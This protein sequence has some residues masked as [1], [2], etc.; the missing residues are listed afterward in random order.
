M[1]RQALRELAPFVDSVVRKRV[2]LLSVSATAAGLMEAAALLLTVRVAVA[3]GTEELDAV[4][5]PLVGS[6]VSPGWVLVVAAICGVAVVG[7]HV[8]NT[9]LTADISSR[10]LHGARSQAVA[11]YVQAGWPTQA[12][13]REGALQETVTTLSI[14]TSL[15]VESLTLGC[16]QAV[17]L[18]VFIGA[19]MAVD[20]VA[21]GVVVV[22]GVALVACLRP[23][24]R[25]TRRRSRVYVDANSAFAE[26]VSRL[27]STSM[28]LRVFGVQAAAQRELAAESDRVR[29]KQLRARSIVLL[30]GGL[31]KD[32]AVLL[33][34]A[35]IGG[36][37][38]ADTGRLAGMA[39]VVAL[40]VRALASAQ[41]V[42]HAY[43]AVN[44]GTSS[45]IALNE[46]LAVLAAGASRVGTAELRH[47]PRIEL[48]RVGY[49]YHDDGPALDEVSLA[50]ESGESLGVV[51]PSGGGKSTFVQVLL[52]LRP[53]SVGAVMIDGTDYRE[54]SDDAWARLV[55]LVPQEPTLLEASIADNIRYYRDIP[56]DEI[57]RAASD[58]NVLDE[59]MRLPADFDTML[60]PRGSGL[61]GGQ[62][63]RVAI[64]RALVGKP[65]LLVMDEPSSALDV[66][67]ERRL[68]ETLERLKG[69]VT[70]VIVAHRMKTVEACDRLLVLEDGRVAQL[71]RPDEL[72]RSDG[73][74]RG[75]VEALQ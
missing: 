20:F 26:E 11:T 51:G 67:S 52:R 10:V 41:A 30:A 56:L 39:V 8:V 65:E 71:G 14:R 50:L 66:H 38:I 68:Q 29:R 55:A 19:S 60:G 6:G 46:R 48:D 28:E 69:T 75:V 34:V 24:S 62:K 4:D 63:Q 45:A 15:L 64:A 58:A 9:R 3:L 16:T 2:A 73:F 72:L 74:Y 21:T 43:Q 42:N 31:Y 5:L 35:C 27:T 33:L 1:I 54:F 12:L 70:M 37:L 40:M 59:I 53:P 49:R 17:S 22:F 44:E 57:E 36:L 18:A 7:L 23:I 25:A 13:Q 47:I 32:L 61:S